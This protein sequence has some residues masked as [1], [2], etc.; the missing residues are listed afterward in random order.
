[1]AGSPPSSWRTV[2]RRIDTGASD[3]AEARAQRSQATIGAPPSVTRAASTLTD[4]LLNSGRTI[5]T[6]AASTRT[7]GS[8]SS[9]A[10][11]AVTS[12][13]PRRS[14][15]SLAAAPPASDPMRSVRSSA[16]SARA[17]QNAQPASNASARTKTLPY[18]RSRLRRLKA[19]GL[20]PA[21]VAPFSSSGV[22][23][24][25]QSKGPVPSGK[26]LN[27]VHKLPTGGAGRGPNCTESTT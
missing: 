1:M 24:E 13:S 26:R 3:Q 16:S 7:P 23:D 11:S 8:S 14:P 18:R 9:S 17:R 4:G 27:D 25:H 5:R 21:H 10:R 15:T 12:A 2:S 20:L 19:Q 22:D 6:P